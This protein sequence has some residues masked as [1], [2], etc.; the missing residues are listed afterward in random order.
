MADEPIDE[1]AEVAPG[2]QAAADQ[3]PDPREERL[4]ALAARVELPSEEAR[5][6]AADRQ[7]TLTKPAGALGRLEELSIWWCGVAGRCPAPPAG[8]PRLVIFAG[9]H[10]IARAAH[11]SAYPTD[12]TAQMVVNFVRGGAAA[13]VLARQ[14][15]VTVRVVD[16]A[17]DIDWQASG[18]PVPTEVTGHK[19]RRASEPLDRA[20]ALTRDEALDA[21][22]AGVS[23]ADEEIDAGADL[24][25]AGDMGIGNT[26]AASAIIALL[27]RQ[28]AARVVGRGTG[29]DDATWMRKTA[30][31]RD[32]TFRAREHRGD[33]VG[34]LAAVGGADIA[35]MAGFLLCAA[36]RGVPVILDGMVVGAAALVANAVSYR[37]REWWLAGH[38]S[39]EPAH[40][41]VLERLRL[42]PVV[43]FQMRLG[44]GSGALVAL[45]VLNAAAATLTEMATFSQAGV[46][47]RPAADAEEADAAATEAD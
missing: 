38:R 25:I 20:D 34:V 15:G 7:L 43:D 36:A 13:N 2:G 4:R 42:T 6:A 46:S 44:E 10:G 45:P 9:D 32:A 47:D 26:T 14:T 28:N 41:T 33:P 16:M 23:V 39:V 35:A 27:T 40:T 1:T 29:I 8:R 22:I 18:H 12:V 19:V 31:V 30:A 11:T 5:L 3:P 37:A 17:V 24:L 21:L